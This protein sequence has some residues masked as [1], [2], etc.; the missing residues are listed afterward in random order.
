MTRP[1][2]RRKLSRWEVLGAWL[3]LWTP[4]RDVDVPP[5]PWRAVGAG[6][7]VVALLIVA[8]I[9]FGL[10]AIRE[11]NEQTA[12]RKQAESKVARARRMKRER[13][14][15]APQR[16]VGDPART[17]AERRALVTELERWVGIDARRRVRAERLKGPIRRVDCVPGAKSRQGGPPE[18]DPARRLGGYDCTAVTSDVAGT[19]ASIGHPYKAVAD[20]ESGHLVWCK[21]N[22]PP[23]EQ[24]AP[25]PR[26]VVE[27]P[28]ACADPA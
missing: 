5:V 26:D 22:P 16:A 11:D 8:F 3:R 19:T 15:Q 2:E 24:V 4:P 27:L 23:G 9:A 17:V 13:A 28:E 6:A 10:P 20:F 7:A 21:V 14:E 18:D 12:A 1:R 25:D